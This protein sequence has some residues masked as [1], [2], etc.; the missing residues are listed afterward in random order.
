[1]HFTARTGFKLDAPQWIERLRQELAGFRPDVVLLDVLRRL[2]DSDENSNQDMAKL[3]NTLND[4]R[5]DFGCGFFIAHHN[6]KLSQGNVKRGRGGQEMSG[7]G[8]LHGW[9]EAALY[10][11]KGSGKG[12]FIVTPEHLTDAPAGGVRIVNEGPAVVGKGEPYRKAILV[13]MRGNPGQTVK[14]IAKAL[15]YHENSVRPHLKALEADGAVIHR[16]ALVEKGH[17]WF[18]TP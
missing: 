11:T 15:E 6:R 16:P 12:K 10:I 3:T 1:L 5:R 13:Y 4:L 18:L 2:H 8:V 7:A 14:Q 17:A 9:S